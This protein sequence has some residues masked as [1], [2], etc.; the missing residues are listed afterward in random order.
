MKQAF[1][2]DDIVVLDE[3]PRIRFADGI[4]MLREAGFKKDDGNEPKED[5]DLST[6]AE[7]KLGARGSSG[8]GSRLGLNQLQLTQKDQAPVKHTDKVKKSHLHHEVSRFRISLFRHYL[9]SVWI[10]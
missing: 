5:E 7:R 8:G 6:S 2:H 10:L 3:T 9:Y 1:P 4:K